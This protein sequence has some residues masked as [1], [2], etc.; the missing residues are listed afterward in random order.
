HVDVVERVEVVSTPTCAGDVVRGALGLKRVVVHGA[1]SR[2]V[3]VL[4]AHLL[5][6]ELDLL[7]TGDAGRARRVDDVQS[8]GVRQGAAADLL[9]LGHVRAGPGVDLV[10]LVPR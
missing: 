9:R 7:G 6:V 4:Q 3:V 8:R 10:R 2:D 5:E 1:R